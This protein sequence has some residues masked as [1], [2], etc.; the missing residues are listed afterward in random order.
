METDVIHDGVLDRQ[1]VVPYV[2]L[3]TREVS[4]KTFGPRLYDRWI[5]YRWTS[6]VQS[7][8]FGGFNCYPV[9]TQV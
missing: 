7:Y 3:V 9:S 6:V 2:V 1:Y 5:H 4:G 8:K